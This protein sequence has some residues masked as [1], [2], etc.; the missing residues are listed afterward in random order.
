MQLSKGTGC[1]HIKQEWVVSVCVD[2]I[3]GWTSIASGP[4]SA[5]MS[6]RAVGPGEPVYADAPNQ[7]VVTWNDV[8]TFPIASGSIEPQVAP[9]VAHLIYL[10][11]PTLSTATEHTL[12]ITLLDTPVEVRLTPIQWEW[13][14][15]Q[16]GVPNIT[17]RT[18][19][20][21]YPDLSVA[22]IYQDVAED[23]VISATILWEGEFRIAGTDTWYPVF[24][25]GTTTVTSEPFDLREY[26]TYLLHDPNQP[27]PTPA[28]GR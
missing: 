5:I 1:K 15:G 9:D 19:G 4:D 22:P 18:P 14:F 27:D 13:D 17:T 28:P 21:H 25:Q 12:T 20:G 6:A 3:T 10:E 2:P 26:R 11:T 8:A 24:G 16:E 23:V 7:L